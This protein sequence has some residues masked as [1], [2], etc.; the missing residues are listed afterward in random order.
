M[1]PPR[2]RLV[3]ALLAVISWPT[4]GMQPSLEYDVKAAFV[5]NFV[6]YT[7]WPAAKRTPPLRL[8]LLDDDPFDGRLGTVVSD[9]PWN[10]GGIEVHV[11][12]DM[13]RARECHLLYVPENRSGMF[14]SN[15]SVLADTPV[16]TVGE[17]ERFLQQG[18][19]I[20]LFVEDNK[21]RFAINQ[22]AA[23]SV[24]ILISSRLLRLARIVIGTGT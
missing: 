8:C 16:L 1:R 6:R 18:G 20:R 2:I 11:V 14:A 10:G 23:D 5:L 15:I 12:S 19:I 4:S 24:G 22:K 13:R 7:E 9:E 17:H 21:I 3:A